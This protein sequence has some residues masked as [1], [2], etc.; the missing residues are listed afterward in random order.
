MIHFWHSFTG[1][2][3]EVFPAL[4]GFEFRATLVILLVLL[5]DI[6]LRQAGPR[7]R[8]A[9]WLVALAGA[10]WPPSLVL[11]ALDIWGRQPAI[12]E[13]LVP[14]VLAPVTVVSA[15]ADPGI[16]IN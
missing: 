7:F 6:I 8:Y 10:L 9:L 4:V 14:V 3:A 2:A 15:A 12:M 16:A 13:T 5:F 11:S 1:W